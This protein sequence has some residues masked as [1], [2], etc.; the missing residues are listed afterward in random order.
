MTTREATGLLP[1]ADALITG[2]YVRRLSD[3]V[4]VTAFG[5][6]QWPWL[7]RS[8]SGGSRAA[9]A[10]LLRRLQL[11]PD[12]LP[13]LGSWKADTGLLELIVDHIAEQRPGMVVEFGAFKKALR[14]YIDGL[15]DH[16]TMLNA[17]DPFVDVLQDAGCKVFLFPADPTVEAV[18]AHVAGIAE[19][20][21]HSVDRADGAAVVAVRLSETH[22]NGA[23]WIA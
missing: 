22:V 7:L 6:I 14:D 5:A 18:A 8:L 12:A 19:G 4:A 2:D 23:S 16:G 1:R 9:K 20:L 15:L 21:L 13:H 11:A 3:R 10:A 17:A